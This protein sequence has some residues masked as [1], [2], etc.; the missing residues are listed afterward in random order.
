M[1]RMLVYLGLAILLMIFL[2]GNMDNKASLNLMG[3]V[4]FKDVPVLI[5]ILSSM[6]A[7][8][9][10]MLPFLYLGKARAVRRERARLNPKEKGVDPAA[11]KK[12]EILEPVSKTA[13]ADGGEGVVS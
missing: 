13:D 3:A 7:G 11:A 5:I 6:L 2:W 12:K 10:L 9:I 1:V 8:M 4:V